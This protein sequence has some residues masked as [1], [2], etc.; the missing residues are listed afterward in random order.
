LC[1]LSLSLS[2]P[3]GWDH[4][5]ITPLCCPLYQRGIFVDRLLFSLSLSLSPSFL[6]FFVVM[7]HSRSLRL[8]LSAPHFLSLALSSYLLVWAVCLSVHASSS[9]ISVWF[10]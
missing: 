4:S 10:F 6:F 1:S 5:S 7:S 3:V 8:S 9:V 2:D